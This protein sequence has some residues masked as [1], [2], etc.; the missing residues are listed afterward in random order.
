MVK[1]FWIGL[2]RF[3][4]GII[5]AERGQGNLIHVVVHGVYVTKQQCFYEVVVITFLLR[6]P[7]MNQGLKHQA[8]LFVGQGQG[9]LP[10]P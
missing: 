4:A 6:K 3:C 8:H 10:S 2:G 1:T 9:V 7:I 5:A